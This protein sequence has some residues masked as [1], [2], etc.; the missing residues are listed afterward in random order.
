MIAHVLTGSPI[1][2]AAQWLVASLLF[3]GAVAALVARRRAWR[4]TAVAVAALGLAGTVTT[5]AVDAAQPGLAPYSLRIV[6]PLGQT[7][8]SAVFTVCGV[9]GDGTLTAASDGQHYLAPFIDGRQAPIVDA[10]Q[11]PLRLPSGAHVV[12]FDLVTPSSQE[13]SPPVTVAERVMVTN[14]AP[15]S[16]PLSC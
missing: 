5:F 7:Q 13:Y 2:A 9:R 1:P 6:A 3:A 12:R 15:A 8:P 10:W 16:G 14:A 4:R 11:V